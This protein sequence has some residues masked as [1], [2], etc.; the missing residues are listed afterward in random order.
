VGP[1]RRHRVHP[2]RHHR[3]VH[4]LPALG[5]AGAEGVQ[6][7][8]ASLR[9]G[10]HRIHGAEQFVRLRHEGRPGMTAT[11]TPT[12]APQVATSPG[13]PAT[14]PAGRRRRSTGSLVGRSVSY[15]I[16]I[17]LAV[18]Y[19]MP[20]LIQIATSFKTD[21]DATA[22]PVSLIPQVWTTAAYT[23]LFLNS[24]FPIWFMNS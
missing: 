24:D 23:K 4:D 2:V 3:G 19:I 20:F 12:V 14:R 15:A 6:A 18:V 7:A 11:T 16:L 13:G 1:G 9:R 8:D 5:A 17:A 10:A 21:A 22:N